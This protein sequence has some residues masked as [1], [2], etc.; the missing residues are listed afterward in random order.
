MVNEKMNF[1]TI[2]LALLW[3]AIATSCQTF[4]CSQNLSNESLTCQMKTLQ[5]GFD[6]SQ[7]ALAKI[8]A[9][10]CSDQLIFESHLTSEHFGKLPNVEE[11]SIT[12][13]KIRHV[14]AKA[15]FGLANLKKLSLQSHSA[16]SMDIDVESLKKVNSLE[17]V[18]FSDN[19]IWSIPSGMMCELLS[20]KL[21]NMSN[22][23]LM[24]ASDLGL[25][26]CR[27]P[28]LQLDLS[29]N[30]ISSL[31]KDDLSPMPSLEIL[32][33][34]HNQI[35]SVFDDTFL[36]VLHLKQVDLSNNQLS[37]LPANLF[38]RSL[39][40]EVLYLQNNSLISL[41]PN[42]LIGL[43]NLQVL[44]LSANSLTSH[45]LSRET[46]SSLASLHTLDLSFNQL[47][48]I[49]TDV[50]SSLTSLQF[51][52]LQNNLIQK[53]DGNAFAN[54]LQL[55]TIELS[56]NKMSS[57]PDKLFSQ[58]GNLLSLK[59]DENLVEDLN[60]VTFKCTNVLEL[61]L[62]AN[63]LTSVPDFIKNCHS[64]TTIDLS[65]NKIIDIA[66][67][68]FTD[69]A[70]LEQ[71]NLSQNKLERLENNSFSSVNTTS[72][73]QMIN[74]SKNKLSTIDQAAFKGL[75]N[76]T[77]LSL[78]ENLLD[79]LNGIL[80]HL[81]TLEWLNVSSNK[82]EWFDLAFLPNSM[83][84]LDLSSN[85]IADLSNFYNLQN[86]RLRVLDA[87]NNLIG[88]I[89]PEC[90]PDG[91]VHVRLDANKISEI[92]PDSISHLENL[93]SF[94]LRLNKI[95]HLAFD[96]LTSS[97]NNLKGKLTVNIVAVIF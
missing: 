86:F 22:N 8:L 38:N 71:V 36:T 4:E 76:L 73:I 68:S 83:T 6:S 75:D 3:L 49:G 29:G 93:E 55:K 88:R 34:S 18:N 61:S 16:I 66:N 65:N 31:N 70:N 90:F 30:F 33:L 45:Q 64:I 91:L 82:V 43:T 13:C 54:Q 78:N 35:N 41:D 58:L 72:N 63:L 80:S 19:N 23:H 67:G 15:F 85:M 17:E 2:S 57:I 51:L 94:D 47:S 52:F 25:S 69:L 53:T 11:L 89:G 28:L 50:F 26:T 95:E 59:M 42:L 32:D 37:A 81:A 46:F 84:V 12:S 87:S 96:A 39:S 24:E 27:I 77:V 40:L 44:N 79:D 5:S 97:Y 1:T 7:L 92:D 14:P 74:L 62:S 60:N 10:H 56:H 48:K 20:M 9:I 21:L